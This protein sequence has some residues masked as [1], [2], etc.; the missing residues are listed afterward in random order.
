MTVKT[1]HDHFRYD[2]NGV[3]EVNDNEDNPTVAASATDDDGGTS[4]D[5]R[6]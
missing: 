5:D 2:D 4:D 3:R 6:D 1:V